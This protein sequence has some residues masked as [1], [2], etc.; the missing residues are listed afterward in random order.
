ME[1]KAPTVSVLMPA[2][3]AEKYVAEAIESILNQSFKD[4]ELIILDDNS[5]DRT[6]KI[7]QEYAEK[8]ARII[9]SKNEI[10]LGIARNRNKLISMARGKYVVWQD[11]DDI[12]MPYR[13]EHQYRF[14]ENNPEVGIS[15]G[16][17][18][19]FDK[20]S[21]LS[22]RKYASDDARVRKNIFRFSPVAQPAAIIRMECFDITGLFPLASPVAEDLA[23]SFQIGTKYKFANLPEI[24]IKYRVQNKNSTHKHLKI[25]ELYSIF[26]RFRYAEEGFYKMRFSDKLYNILQGA[27]MLVLPQRFKFWIFRVIRNSKV[28]K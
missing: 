24:L 13:I 23:M 18:L 9:F 26:L 20:N 12:S 17:L 10:N 21:E 15:G 7:A 19:F 14:M 3:N 28:K 5:K 6:F 8:D 22:I 25:M 1:T 2:Y 11:A 27:S 4:F 16:W